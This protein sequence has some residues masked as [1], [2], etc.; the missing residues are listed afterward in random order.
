MDVSNLTK[1]AFS[2][3]KK[4]SALKQLVNKLNAQQILFYTKNAYNLNLTS[5]EVGYL[6]TQKFAKELKEI[7]E[8]AKSEWD[9]PNFVSNAEEKLK[10]FETKL[11]DKKINFHMLLIEHGCCEHNLTIKKNV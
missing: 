3:G 7:T 1:K 8:M 11:L 4:Y 5:D 9:Y 6:K 10:S 2:L